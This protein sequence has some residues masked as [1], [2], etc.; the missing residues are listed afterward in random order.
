M[1]FVYGVVSVCYDMFVCCFAFL[2][3]ITLVCGPPFVYDVM[4]VF[5]VPC[6]YGAT[7]MLWFHTF[8]SYSEQTTLFNRTDYPEEVSVQTYTVA[9]AHSCKSDTV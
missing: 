6:V 7:F 5:G 9:K 4:L 2:P 8:H 3:D 1:L